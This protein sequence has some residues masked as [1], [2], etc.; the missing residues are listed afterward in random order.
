VSKP[1]Y[2]TQA[3]FIKAQEQ[4]QHILYILQESKKALLKLVD[5][6]AEEMPRRLDENKI[7]FEYVELVEM[8]EKI[9]EE[10]KDE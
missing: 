10:L 2:R 9:C 8:I 1:Y 7:Y 3:E 4:Q 5:E 6:A